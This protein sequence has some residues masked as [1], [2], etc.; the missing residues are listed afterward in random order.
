MR[1]RMLALTVADWPDRAIGVLV[2]RRRG[3]RLR[4]PSH[5]MV[6]RRDGYNVSAK[7]RRAADQSVTTSNGYLN[8]V[9]LS[10]EVRSSLK[11]HGLPNPTLGQASSEVVRDVCVVPSEDGGWEAVS[12]GY[13]RMI[14]ISH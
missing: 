1:P 12:V 14:R 11:V 5:V 10:G 9:S 6:A 2:E 13:D 3:R 4:S 7:T 8:L